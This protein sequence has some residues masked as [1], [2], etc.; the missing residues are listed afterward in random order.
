M[1]KGA[2]KLNLDDV[3]R[4]NSEGEA[5]EYEP[6][7]TF[8]DGRPLSRAPYIPTYH[9]HQQLTFGS[10]SPLKRS[11]ADIA[12]NQFRERAAAPSGYVQAN[13]TE[14]PEQ[15]SLRKRKRN[16]KTRPPVAM[17]RE[18][19]EVS[20][21][22]SETPVAKKRTKMSTLRAE[23]AAIQAEA[24]KLAGQ[25]NDA[26]A[27]KDSTNEEIV[28]LCIRIGHAD[29]QI[30]SERAAMQNLRGENNTSKARLKA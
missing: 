2:K 23:K 18:V 26:I 10:F 3:Q 22:A 28:A 19:D 25:L 27:A 17:T 7:D 1:A 30:L 11:D 12:T 4:R 6:S 9:P 21:N 20:L 16:E 8:G 14:P 13:G 29:A 24:D 15:T 5:L